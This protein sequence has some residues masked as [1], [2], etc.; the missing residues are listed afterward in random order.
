[1]KSGIH[2]FEVDEFFG[3]N[4]GLIVAEVELKFED[5]FFEKPNWLGDEVTGDIKYY[6]SQ[7]SK[8]PFKT[9]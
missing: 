3:N 8:R 1:V 4:E 6:N 5:E 9:W 2:V 7:L